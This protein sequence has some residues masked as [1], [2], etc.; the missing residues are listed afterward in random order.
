MR[1]DLYGRIPS[2]IVIGLACAAETLSDDALKIWLVGK[3]LG[4]LKNTGRVSLA[5]CDSEP[6]RLRP[7]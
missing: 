5:A 7:N 2:F 4:N 1:K 3:A 6:T